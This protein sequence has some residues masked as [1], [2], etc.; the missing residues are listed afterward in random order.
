MFTKLLSWFNNTWIVFQRVLQ[1]TWDYTV[2]GWVWFVGVFYGFLL[3]TD[4]VIEYVWASFK[5]L[6]ELLDK[7]VLSN[8][9]VTGIADSDMLATINTFF[10]LAEFFTLLSVYSILFTTG[11]MYRFCKSLI[12]GVS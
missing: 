3:V 9:S 6:F 7:L 11:L 5:E 12:P 4:K 2:Q 8:N 10:P 1:S